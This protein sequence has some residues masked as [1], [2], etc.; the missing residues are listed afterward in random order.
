MVRM[1]GKTNNCSVSFFDI[2]MSRYVA[3]K[4]RGWESVRE[5]SVMTYTYGLNYVYNIMS[6][7]YMYIYIYRL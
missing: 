2:I 5:E 3:S 4:M 7:I 6:S 1:Y